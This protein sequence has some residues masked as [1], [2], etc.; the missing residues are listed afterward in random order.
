MPSQLAFHAREIGLAHRKG[1]GC[2]DEQGEQDGQG[3]HEA[4]EEALDDDDDRDCSKSAPSARMLRLPRRIIRPYRPRQRCHQQETDRSVPM[5]VVECARD[6]RRE[7][8]QELGER[9]DQK[10][11]RPTAMEPYMVAISGR[12]RSARRRC[13]RADRDE[14]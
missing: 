9:S 3:A 12:R 1:N 11:M 5:T 2:H 10:T 8:A 13:S 4:L 7:E 14:G 6:D